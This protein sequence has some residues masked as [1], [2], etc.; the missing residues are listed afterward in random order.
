[1]S[2]PLT[3]QVFEAVVDDPGA[4]GG[5]GEKAR[6][7][8]P[9][10]FLLHVASLSASKIADG[11]LNPKL[12]LSWLVTHLGAGAG[13]AGLLV[14]VR[15]AGALLPQLFTSGAIHGMARRKWA[16]AGGAAGQGLAAAGIV[17]VALTQEGR[18]AGLLIVA[19]LGL[20]A[21]SRS[22]CSVAYKDVL[23]KT[24]G[25]TRRGTATGLASTAAS[26]AVILF[27]LILVTGWGER[28]VVVA[29]ALA[30]AAGLWLIAGAV[31]ATLKEIPSRGDGLGLRESVG[32]MRL[33]AERPQLARFILSRSLLVG[34]ALA[35]PYL[36]VLAAGGD[37]GVEA[38]GWLVLASSAASF[39]SSFV[40]GR[41]SDR[42]SRKVLIVAGLAGGAAMGLAVLLEWLGLAEVL[43]AMPVTLF[44]LMIAYHGVRQ[45][46][47]TYLVDM[48]RGE[49]RA[50]YTAVSNTAV[51]LF[52]LAAGAGAAALAAL[53]TPLALTV[54]AVMS[55]A[56]AAVAL[57][58][59]EVED[60]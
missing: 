8:E 24:V 9:R 36:L 41:F 21:L 31:F 1:M 23:G 42:S 49:D 27:A 53:S 59:D 51:G 26:A 16:W 47:S 17:L 56:G 5:L 19:L 45:G 40:W 4:E 6:Q 3:E 48:A 10:N 52:L 30:L 50:A 34:T 55:V 11:L 13:V 35:P 7:A 32:Q 33:I 54:F 14:P 28:F 60:G 57:G 43:W 37:G 39:A 15:E 46:R 38:L 18:A 12:V 58:L 29:T 20:L 25:K 44:L 22:V 2:K